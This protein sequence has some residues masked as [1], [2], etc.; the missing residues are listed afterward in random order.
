MCSGASSSANQLTDRDL[1][2][3]RKGN[4]ISI[5]QFEKYHYVLSDYIR[6]QIFDSKII[7]EYIENSILFIQRNRKNFRF[8]YYL[9]LI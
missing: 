7:K 1:T 8:E 4:L 5:V 9:S 2:Y 6:I 3:C